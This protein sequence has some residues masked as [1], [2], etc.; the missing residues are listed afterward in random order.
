MNRLFE[1][2]IWRRAL[3]RRTAQYALMFKFERYGTLFILDS[4]TNVRAETLF[5]ERGAKLNGRLDNGIDV[6]M[7]SLTAR[8]E[9]ESAIALTDAVSNL[10]E[11]SNIL[12]EHFGITTSQKHIRSIQLLL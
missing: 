6:L 3:S 8:L 1:M 4:S 7:L 12:V 5:F 9:A 10:D 2:Q 11:T